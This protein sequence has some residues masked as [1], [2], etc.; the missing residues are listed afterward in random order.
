MIDVG[1]EDD[2]S[3]ATYSLAQKLKRL[4]EGV[5][6]VQSYADVGNVVAY[7]LALLLFRI[8]RYSSLPNSNYNNKKEIWPPEAKIFTKKEKSCCRP[9]FWPGK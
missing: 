3:S 8:R 9:F 5:T 6:F 4:T 1:V 7:Q 2:R